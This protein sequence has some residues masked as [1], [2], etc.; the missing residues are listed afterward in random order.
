MK[1]NFNVRS[2]FLLRFGLAILFATLISIPSNLLAQDQK[3]IKGTIVDKQTSQ[4]MPDVSVVIKGS[5]AGTKTG[6]DGAYTI[7]AKIGD[8]IVF[9]YAGYNSY[10]VKVQNQ[11]VIDYKLE[12]STS[13]LDEVVV[14][15]YSTSKRRDLTG[16]VCICIRKRNSSC[17]GYEC[18]PGHAREISR[19]KCCFTRWPS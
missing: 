12:L 6:T 9:S 8:V 5:G 4:P 3:T 11:T 17:A 19:G 10:Q 1:I 16:S 15:G 2:H 13:T 7:N 14:I 18:G